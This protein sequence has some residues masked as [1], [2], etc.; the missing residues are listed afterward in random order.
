MPPKRA[1]MDAVNSSSGL[2]KSQPS[3]AP[4]QLHHR[5]GSSQRQLPFRLRTREQAKEARQA[6]VCGKI[7]L[8]AP[9]NSQEMGVCCPLP[10]KGLDTTRSHTTQWVCGSSS[11]L[12]TEI[13]D[14]RQETYT[15]GIRGE[16]KFSPKQ[17][18]SPRRARQWRAWGLHLP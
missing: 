14:R 7:M 4:P 11:K 3:E 1:E 17:K 8:S 13:S 12:L 6:V 9:Y 16:K 5:A 10:A 2:G 18:A 15:L